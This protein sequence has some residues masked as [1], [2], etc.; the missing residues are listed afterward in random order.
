MKYHEASF[1]PVTCSMQELKRAIKAAPPTS[2]RRG[3]LK[4]VEHARTMIA[5]FTGNP[6]IAR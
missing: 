4:G 5:G 1:C 2:E 3:F 6:E